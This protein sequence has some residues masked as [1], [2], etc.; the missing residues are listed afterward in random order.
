M[1]VAISDISLTGW[2]PRKNFNK[3]ALDE[4]KKSIKEH[5]ILEPL[6]VRPHNGSYQLV[7]GERRYR[8]AKELGLEKVPVVVQ[9]LDD[10]SVKEIM[11]LENLQREDLSPLEEAEALQV[12]LQDGTTQEELGKKL[13][14][15]QAWIANRVRLL[16]AP[17]ELKDLLI[18]REISPKHVIT[19]LPF[20]EYATF[21]KDILPKLREVIKEKGRISVKALEELIE[22]TI[23]S[24]G[25]DNV[26]CL[27][28]PSFEYEKYANFLDLSDCNGCKH[29]V[30]YKFW[31]DTDRRYC[32]N[33]R[34]WKDKVNIAKQKYEKERQKQRVKHNNRL[35]DTAE[36][37]WDEYEF[38]DHAEW[39][40]TEC[41]TCDSRAMSTDN[42]DIC[43]DPECY[44]KKRGDW[45]REQNKKAREEE[46][47]TYE[48]LD[49]KL[50]QIKELGEK[51]LRFIV[52]KLASQLW[53]E[54]VKKALKP[55]GKVAKEED[56]EK[57]Y[58]NIPADELPIAVLRLVI[59]NEII[60]AYSNLT[61][62][63]L[64]DVL[65]GLGV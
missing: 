8:A 30:T 42:K 19:L 4:L 3:D 44:K 41:M 28:K 32:L 29:A 21:K 49:N 60:R 58:K 1:E 43:M 53:A 22:D 23:T 52:R 16:Q 37:D 2:N 31:D 15:S 20:T 13:G 33:R 26:F 55:W 45:T 47:R 14:K 24:Y 48:E 56:R 38:L 65:E 50:S 34:C 6:V 5:G 12:L 25:N 35:V 59:I 39:D 51:E 64:N 11:L 9:H 40:T 7:A 27:D 62:E 18:S 54:S 46:K 61:Q 57:I 63:R 17:D 10:R 36:L